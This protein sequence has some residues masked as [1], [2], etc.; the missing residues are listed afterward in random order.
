[1]IKRFECKFIYLREGVMNERKKELIMIIL[2]YLVGDYHVKHK[3]VKI[4]FMYSF[5][6]LPI[7]YYTS[8]PSPP[9]LSS[10][11]P[12]L[13]LLFISFITLFSLLFQQIISISQP[14]HHDHSF[15]FHL[16]FNYFYKYIYTCL[17]IIIVC[18]CVCEEIVIIN[19]K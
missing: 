1:M 14:I 5:Y 6:L 8:S 2:H 9:L 7:F 19:S 16:F 12:S 18:V 11:Y 17:Y 4:R 15:F 13:P 10:Y 3:M